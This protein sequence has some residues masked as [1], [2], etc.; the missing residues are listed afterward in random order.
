[1]KV[2]KKPVQRVKHVPQRTCVGCREVLPKRKMIRLV[3]TTD[4]VQVDLTSKL[5]GRGAYL[6]DRH[7]CWER[8]LKGAL[9]HALKTDL[10]LNDRARLEEFMNNLPHE[11][12]VAG[13]GE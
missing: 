11:A 5:A 6:H 2:T 7:E 4:G 10:S 8:A 3:R 1:M 13:I 9:G 12:D